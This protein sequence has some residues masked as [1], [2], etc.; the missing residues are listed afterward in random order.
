MKNPKVIAFGILILL[1][2]WLL[3]GMLQERGDP[4]SGLP[5]GISDVPARPLLSVRVREQMARPIEQRVGFSGK[6]E[7]ARRVRLKAETRGRVET[8][9]ADRGTPL[10]AGKT[11]ATIEVLDRSDQLAQAKALVEQ[12]QLEFEAANK[13]ADKGY[14][15]TTALA[16]ARTQLLAAEALVEQIEE[17][18]ENT[19]V[20]VPFDAFLLERHV[21]EGDY[22]MAGDPIADLIELDPIIVSGQLTEGEV[23]AIR[24]GDLGFARTRNGGPVLRGQ[25]RYVAP[26]GDAA[27][28]TFRVELE[29][30]NPSGEVLAG[31]TCDVEIPTGSILA[32]RMSP[33][34]LSLDDAGVLGVK[35]VGPDNRVVFYPVEMVKAETE[36]IW[37]SGLPETFQLIVVGQGFAR[38]G[39]TV[40]PVPESEAGD[41]LRGEPIA[42]AG[43]REN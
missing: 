34:L 5:Q 27:S 42:S 11:I 23:A 35:A 18:L 33:A 43:L 39:D 17:D 8:V 14:Q 28:R 2:L 13:L 6:T 7:P 36:H 10:E 24:I 4:G 15:A 3:S 19:V 9:P 31:I 32:H 1:G 22:V 21:E 40:K 20:S 29:C 37:L 38:V 41:S 16:Q 30:P 25:V 12:R 26:E